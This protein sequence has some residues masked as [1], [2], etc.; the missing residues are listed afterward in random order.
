MLDFETAAG[1]LLDHVENGTVHPHYQHMVNTAAWCRKVFSGEGQ[2]EDIRLLRPSETGEQQ[3]FRVTVSYPETPE[4]LEGVQTICQR[5][6]R[7]DGINESIVHPNATLRQEV[8]RVAAG[9]SSLGGV[10]EYLKDRQLY[11]EFVD[12]N[13]WLIVERRDERDANGEVVRIQTYPLEVSATEAINYRTGPSEPDYLLVRHYRLGAKDGRRLMTLYCYCAG[14]VTVARQL[15]EEELVEEDEVS[16]TSIKGGDT[17]ALS[18]YENDTLHF[19]GHKFGAYHD[20]RVDDMSVRAPIYH[21]ARFVLQ[22]I[23]KHASLAA[24]Q[25]MAHV[26]PK[27]FAYDKPCEYESEQVVGLGC[28]FHEGPDPQC[29][30]CG[31]TGS[32]YHKSDLD[33]VRIRLPY[34]GEGD[35]AREVFKLSD[36]IYYVTVPLEPTKLILE[37]LDLDKRTVPFSVFNSAQIEQPLVAVTATEQRFNWENANN[38]VEPLASHNERLHTVCYRGTAEHLGY[39]EKFE[40]HRQFPKAL[41][42]EPEDSIIERYGRAKEA[43]LPTVITQGI[44]VEL[45][46][47]RF[48]VTSLLTRNTVALNAFKPFA[49]LDD[50]TVG[51]ITAKRDPADAGVLLWENWSWVCQHV[52]HTEPGFYAAGYDE[53]RAI[54]DGIVESLRGQV[55]YLAT[56]MEPLNLSGME[57][58]DAPPQ[59][60]ARVTTPSPTT[61]AV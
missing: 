4:V 40:Y 32:S 48:G 11:Y 60:G 52:H 12:P 5:I 23:V 45:L 54:I 1:L 15:D 14:S 38:R 28:G 36:L 49:N 39:G 18:Y 3:E 34:Q 31:G 44:E 30:K 20:T 6:H 22:R 29:P 56:N 17:Y 47:K 53:Q 9:F 43:G 55:R 2:A 8:V 58:E 50:V 51:A 16:Y 41:D 46:Q 33:M 35:D 59:G 10:T 24:V 27:L 61:E 7:V 13:A 42:L 25:I 21:P 57:S 26:Y 19:P 37:R